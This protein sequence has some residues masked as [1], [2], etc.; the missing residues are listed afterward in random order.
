[1]VG[2]A[3]EGLDSNGQEGILGLTKGWSSGFKKWFKNFIP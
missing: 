3:L 2:L 1:V